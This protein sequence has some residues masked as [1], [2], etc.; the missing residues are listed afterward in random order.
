[1]RIALGTKN[2]HLLISYREPDEDDTPERVVNLDGD[3]DPAPTGEV[4]SVDM[5]FGFGVD[6]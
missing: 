1:M 6:G 4:E 2:L 3:F 5:T